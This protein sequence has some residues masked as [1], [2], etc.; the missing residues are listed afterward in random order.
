M[1]IQTSSAVFWTCL[2]AV[3][4]WLLSVLLAVPEAI[5]SQVVSMQS[6]QGHRDN[7]N[8]TSLNC[9]PYPLSN[10]MHP[11]I[12]SVMIFLVYFLIPLT[13][14][15]VYYYHIAR[16]LIK[17]AHEMPGEVSEHTKRQ[18]F[19]AFYCWTSLEIGRQWIPPGGWLIWGFGAG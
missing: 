1:D 15:S 11:K 8:V 19:S 9:V 17:S 5:F 12:H 7:M 4:I 3:S 6:P 10:Q 18:G 2:K 16:T 14:I 13:I